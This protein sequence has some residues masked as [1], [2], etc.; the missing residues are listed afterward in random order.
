MVL[1]IIGILLSI[2]SPSVKPPIEE[3]KL[4]AK[5]SNCTGDSFNPAVGNNNEDELLF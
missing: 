2:I 5:H 3:V 4:K 1:A